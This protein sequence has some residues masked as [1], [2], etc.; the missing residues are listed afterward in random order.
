M[1]ALLQP[2]PAPS[3]PSSRG[4]TM[5]TERI[6]DWKT[7]KRTSISSLGEARIPQGSGPFCFF[8]PPGA[9]PLSNCMSHALWHRRMFFKKM[10]RGSTGTGR[11]QALQIA[12][13]A[14]LVARVVRFTSG[15]P[16]HHRQHTAVG[17]AWRDVHG[18][19]PHV[20]R[21]HLVSLLATRAW[22]QPKWIYAFAAE[23]KRATPEGAKSTRSPINSYPGG[24]I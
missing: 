20:Q 8:A 14:Q 5:R 13:V 22:T 18:V 10:P 4:R 3:R 1:V 21:K 15:V 16:K 9:M 2:F 6:R 23:R 12:D 11:K 17:T 19:A 7:C 24:S